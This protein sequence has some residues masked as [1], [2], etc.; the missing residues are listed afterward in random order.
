MRDVLGAR[1]VPGSGNGWRQ[2]GDVRGNQLVVSCKAE[3]DRG[4]TWARIRE[5][6]R[7]AID[8]SFGT[9]ATPMLALLEDDG[10]ELVVMRLPDYVKV[11]EGAPI[12]GQRE[13]SDTQRELADMP[14]I[15]R[16]D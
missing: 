1:L 2:K 6:L 13:R 15:L 14:A 10:E 9:G 3:T 11:L 5:Q 8:M 12:A 7:E 16:E 4:K